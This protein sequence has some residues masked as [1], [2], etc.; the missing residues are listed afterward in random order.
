VGLV[1]AP[2]P[3]WVAHAPAL[4]ADVDY[5]VVTPETTWRPEGSTWG[6]NGWWHRFRELGQRYARPF[7]GHGVGWSTGSVSPPHR[8]RWVEALR[9]DAVAF[10]F[11]WYTEHSGLTVAGGQHLTLPLP[12]PFDTG[13]AATTRAA[14]DALADLVPVVGLENSALPFVVG[15]PLAE[16]GWLGRAVGP[17]H[18]LL[19]LPNLWTMALNLGFDP[20]AWLARAPLDRVIE[21]H[22]SGGSWTGDW[23]PGRP[24]RL[25][26]HDT[27][28]PPEVWDLLDH[29]LPRCPG[30]RGVTVER[31]EGTLGDDDVPELLGDLRRLRRVLT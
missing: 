20:L 23:F 12:V 8:R 13:H 29:V 21:L 4:V 30:L 31:M 18:L 9:R 10:G 17:H 15:D 27:A 22:L 7:V 5:L 26:S 3:A 19:D 11:R 6:A 1:L 14:L 2:D 28:V 25:D 16:P 24:Q